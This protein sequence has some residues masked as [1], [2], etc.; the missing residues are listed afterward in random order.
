[1]VLPFLLN[2]MRVATILST[3]VF[4]LISGAVFSDAKVGTSEK[5]IDDQHSD[6]AEHQKRVREYEEVEAQKDLDRELKKKRS[7]QWRKEQA[8]LRKE[9]RQLR[10]DRLAEIRSERDKE[11]SARAR[12]KEIRAQM[13][14]EESEYKTEKVNRKM[15]ILYG[16]GD[17]GEGADDEAV[18]GESSE[19]KPFWE[20]LMD[21]RK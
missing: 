3:V 6:R 13:A 1:M 20:K 14:I 18:D 21:F 10:S 15:D 5:N 4:F 9:F 12:Q 8:K 19:E 17:A 7:A 2:I 11:L 16:K